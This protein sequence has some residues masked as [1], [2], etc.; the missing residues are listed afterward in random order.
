MYNVY[1]ID[2]AREKY[3]SS[4]FLIYFHTLKSSSK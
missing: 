2:V 4:F 1:T 3:P